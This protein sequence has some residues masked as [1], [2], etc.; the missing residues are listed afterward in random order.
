[1]IPPFLALLVSPLP[2]RAVHRSLLSNPKFGS[3]MMAAAPAYEEEEEG[4]REGDEY[5]A[6]RE[7]QSYG[8]GRTASRWSDASGERP[9]PERREA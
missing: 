4:Q 6:G 3:T 8:K 2:R 7:N 1:M 9:L 5:A